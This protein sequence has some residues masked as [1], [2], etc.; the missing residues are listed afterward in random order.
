[1][2]RYAQHDMVLVLMADGG[3]RSA[4]GGRRSA[5]GG[6]RSADGGRNYKDRPTAPATA[7][8]FGIRAAK[9]A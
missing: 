2:L 5:V 6:R 7:T 8:S 3:R 4:D 9:L 1:M